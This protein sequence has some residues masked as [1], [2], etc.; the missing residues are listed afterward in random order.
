MPKLDMLTLR[1]M[2]LT[3]IPLAIV[4]LK[5]LKYLNLDNNDQLILPE[6]FNTLAKLKIEELNLSSAKFNTVPTEITQLKH[7]KTLTL[8]M[9]QGKFNNKESYTTLS[10]LKKLECLNLQGNFFK[11]FD[12][13]IA[14]LKKL[15]RIEVDGN[16]LNEDEFEKLKGYLPNT[17]IQN[18]MPC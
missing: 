4:K 9:I 6:T 8:E 5:N 17:E 16:C 14:L 3:S 11:A 13:S 18:E 12:P 2:N 7:L 15:K 1:D 10:N